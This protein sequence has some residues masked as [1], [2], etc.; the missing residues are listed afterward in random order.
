MPYLKILS[1]LS[2]LAGAS[3]VMVW[4]VRETRSPVTPR[5]IV[6]PPAG[7]ATGFAMFLAPACRVPW[8]WALA[9]FLVGALVLSYPLLR[10]TRLVREGDAVMMQ[11]SNAF[12]AILLGLAAIRIGARGY[13]DTVLS[14]PQTAGLFFILAFGMI[15]RW[16]TR[17]LRDYR[18]LAAGPNAA[19]DTLRKDTTT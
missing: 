3:A 17:M 6:I 13:L 5:K 2:S 7:M 4:R 9:A 12:F 18:A 14:V 8:S 10:T 1:L 19:R 11:R 15:L 16:R